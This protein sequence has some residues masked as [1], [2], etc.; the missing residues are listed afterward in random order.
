MIQEKRCSRQEVIVSRTDLEGKIIYCNPTFSKINGFKDAE[1]IH[2]HHSIV[3]HPDM[4]KTIFRIIW[5]IIEQGLPI[6]AIIKNKTHDGH[7]YWTV[8]D[9]KVQRDRDDK[10]ISYIAYGKQAPDHAIKA[11][12]TL[13]KTMLLIEKEHDIDTSLEFLNAFLANK[14]LSYS[15]YL[16]ELTKHRKFRCF[17]NF[18]KHSIFRN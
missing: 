14:E 11:I 17:C 3:R 5:S 13:Y 6:Q 18:I 15:Q 4:P 2:Q 10:V 12:E 1:M 7:Y 16:K 8:V 9:F